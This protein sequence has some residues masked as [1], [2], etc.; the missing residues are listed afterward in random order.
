[1]VCTETVTFVTCPSVTWLIGLY[2]QVLNAA[3]ITSFVMS[4]CSS[5]GGTVWS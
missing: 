2:P 4:F 3:F 1:M 5:N